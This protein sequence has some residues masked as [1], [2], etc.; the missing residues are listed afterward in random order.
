MTA[1]SR[2]PITAAGATATCRAKTSPRRSITSM[3]RRGSQQSMKLCSAAGG[4]CGQKA[5]KESTAARR[6]AGDPAWKTAR[7]TW[8]A[9]SA[10]RRTMLAS[11]AT[12]SWRS[13][14]EPCATKRSSSGRTGSTRPSWKFARFFCSQWSRPPASTGAVTARPRMPSILPTSS[15]SDAPSASRSSSSQPRIFR[16]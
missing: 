1:L 9:G 10:P 14:G 15:S 8:R 13:A 7:Q 16:W 6:S 12:A 11:I 4:S 3:S 2:K 5:M